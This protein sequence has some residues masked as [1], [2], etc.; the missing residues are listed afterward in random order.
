MADTDLKPALAPVTERGYVNG[1][2]DWQHWDETEQVPDLQWPNSIRVFKRMAREDTRVTSLIKAITLPILRTD[3]RLD[4]NGASDEVVNFV[5]DNLGLAIKG[6]PEPESRPRQRGRFSWPKHLQ[7]ALLMLK[8]GHSYFEQVYFIDSDG[9]AR[10]R[11]LAPRPQSSIARINVARDG[12][13]ISIEQYAPGGFITGDAIIPV[14]RLVAYVRDP[15]PGSWIGESILRPAYKHWILKDE[16]MRIQAATSRRNGMGVPMYQGPPGASQDDLEKGRQMASEYRGGMNAGLAIPDEADFKLLGV[17]GN[18]PDM[19]QAINYH[20]KQIALAGLAH[21][22]NLDGGGSYALATVQESVF[23]ESVQALAE[24]VR[25]TANAHIVED[26][27]DINFGPDEPAPRIVFDDIGTREEAVAAAL[28]LLVDAGILFP[29][30][31]LEEAVR[32]KYG[33]PA[34]DTPPPTP[35]GDS[36]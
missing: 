36:A 34:K 19:Q 11:K 16:F 25:D 9:R 4:T 31:T 18:L 15:E 22:L 32:D 21:F 3:W 33:L 12:G 35:Q 24:D 8:Y 20:D 10:L 2:I 14:E 26:L 23:T 27:V 7:T 13:L 30:R 28:K 6:Q 17:Q 5:A 1:N 29:D